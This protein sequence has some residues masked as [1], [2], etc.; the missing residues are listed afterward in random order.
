[1]SRT[2]GVSRSVCRIAYQG[3]PGAWSEVA[4]LRAQGQPRAC[5]DFA[6]T[7]AA[8]RSGECAFAALPI[9]NSLG[10]SLYE[11]YDLLGREPV[12]IV[13]DTY[14]PIDDRV[15]GLPGATVA[16]ARRVYSHPLALEECADFFRQHPHLKAAAAYDTAGAAAFVA[17]AGDPTRLAVASPRAGELHSLVDLGAAVPPGRASITRFLYLSRAEPAAGREPEA[18]PAW[19]HGP[20]P[21]KTSLVLRLP[22]RRGALGEVLAACAGQ[23]LSVTKIEL[24]P[25][26]QQ[27]FEYQFFLDFEADPAEPRVHAAVAALSASVEE[28]RTLGSYPTI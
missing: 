17:A 16:A 10:G 15:L 28:A 22:G 24:R 21:H 3:E 13:A 12:R 27:P 1:M 6:A 2:H 9:E 23:E 11:N 5:H 26:R 8:L 18:A 25:T 19:A 14:L 7:F 4:A 20:G